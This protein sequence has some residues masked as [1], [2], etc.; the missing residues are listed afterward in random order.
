MIYPVIFSLN[1]GMFLTFFTEQRNK[2]DKMDANEEEIICEIME[3]VPFSA[4]ERHQ[5]SIM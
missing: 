3:I 5:N 2:D 4:L 1:D